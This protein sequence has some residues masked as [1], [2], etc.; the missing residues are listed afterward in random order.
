MNIFV[1]DYDYNKAADYHADKHICKMIVETAQMLCTAYHILGEKHKINT[2]FQRCGKFYKKTH[3]NH[4]CSIMVRDN[5]NNF[6]WVLQLGLRLCFQYYI[7][8]GDHSKNHSTTPLLLEM[9]SRRPYLPNKPLWFAQAMPEQYKNHDTIIAYR[10]YYM[11]EKR[12]IA[13]WKY[14]QQPEWWI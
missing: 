8:F 9:E 14:T 13:K 11:A 10:N 7:R 5:I 2:I 6:D 1:L 4:P 12:H 3:A